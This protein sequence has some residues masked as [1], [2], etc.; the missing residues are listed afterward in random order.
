[1]KIK[2][3][4]IILP[5]YNEAENIKRT[6]NDML[7]FIGTLA[8]TYEIII[9]N[10]G[11]QDHTEKVLKRINNKHV[12]KLYHKTNRGYGAALTTGFT[13]AKHNWIFFTDSD[14]QFNIQNIVNFF[15]HT[16][17]SDM[18]I[19]YRRRRQD[20]VIRIINARIFNIVVRILF[21]LSVRDIDC[22]FKLFKKDVILKNPLISK[23]ALIN[24]ELLVKARKEGY[25]IHELPVDHYPRIKGNATG[26]NIF[27]ILRAAHELI[28]FRLS[29]PI[30]S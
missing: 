29:T 24:T 5:C 15:P 13:N 9:V 2:Q 14:G 1:M 25:K 10:D 18:I 22:A 17:S 28:K 19:G 26:A 27:V 23:G 3:L 7:D 8:I 30:F 21:N 12:I 4:S 11:S 16:N 20:T 6:V